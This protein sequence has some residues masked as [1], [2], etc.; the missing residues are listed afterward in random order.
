MEKKEHP[1]YESPSLTVIPI[2]TEQ[3][4]AIS[5]ATLMKEETLWFEFGNEDPHVTQ[6]DDDDSWSSYSWSK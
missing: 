1:I 4:Y 5:S 2:K 3:G 6:Y